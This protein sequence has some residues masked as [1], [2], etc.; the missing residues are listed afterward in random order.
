MMLGSIT[1]RFITLQDFDAV[2]IASGRYNAPNMPSIEGLE[3]WRRKFNDNILHSRQY[4]HPEDYSGKTILIVGAAVSQSDL[5]WAQT[6]E[7]L[8]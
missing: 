3:Q 1:P 6:S 2:V 7:D 8:F 5:N 4:R